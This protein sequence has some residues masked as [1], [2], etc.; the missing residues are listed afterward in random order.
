MVELDEVN[1]GTLYFSKVFFFKR[2]IT[3]DFPIDDSVASLVCAQLTFLAAD[4]PKKPIEIHLNSPGGV[5]TAG[6]AILDTMNFIQPD[7]RVI[8][9][10]Q[11]AS[12]GAVL[13]CSGTEGM[14]GARARVRP[15]Q[16]GSDPGQTLADTEERYRRRL[17]PGV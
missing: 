15:G 13:L 1:I 16:Q 6:L 7:V 11:A 8:C 3:L 10:G 17:G 2:I 5:V 12:M 9:R 14:R 4:D